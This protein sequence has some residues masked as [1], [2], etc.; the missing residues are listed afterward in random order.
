MEGV[1]A[2]L[3]PIAICVVLPV[4]I[5]WIYY[6]SVNNTE[7]RRADILLKAIETNNDID[8]DKLAEA[9][10]GSQKRR[11]PRQLLNLR[12][13]R[14]CIFGLVGIMLMIVCAV[15]YNGGPIAKDEVSFPLLVLGLVSFAI[16]V[17][18]LVVYFVTRK[19]VEKE[20]SE[21][22]EGL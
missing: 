12:L 20:E 21:E 13:L 22:E 16:G 2:L 8:T 5:V 1:V 3:I 14:G 9:F 11:T 6:K 15:T 18:Y 19:A 17:S 10:A 4:S 7:N